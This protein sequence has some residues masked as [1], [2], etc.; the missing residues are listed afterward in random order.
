MKYIDKYSSASTLLVLPC[1]RAMASF[2]TKPAKPILRSNLQIFHAKRRNEV[3]VITKGG[4]WWLA[5][6]CL[7]AQLLCQTFLRKPFKS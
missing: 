7:L 1:L 6:V 4:R 5:Y 2:Q 3:G